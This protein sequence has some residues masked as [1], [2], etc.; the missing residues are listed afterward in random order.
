M[1]YVNLK[2][3]CPQN[4]GSAL[5]DLFII[6]YNERG[7]EAHQNEMFFLDFYK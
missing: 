2:I 1:V 3:L 5:E 7:E 4:S 6:V